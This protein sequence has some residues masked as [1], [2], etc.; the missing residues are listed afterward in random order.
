MKNSYFLYYQLWLMLGLGN[1][2]PAQSLPYTSFNLLRLP[3]SATAIA[4][5]GVQVSSALPEPSMMTQNPALLQPEAARRASLSVQPWYADIL[6]SQVAVALPRGERAALGLWVQYL[7]YG[8]IPDTDPGGQTQGDFQAADWSIGAAYSPRLGVFR[9]GGSVQILGSH[10]AGYGQYALA[11]ILGGVFRHPD[12]DFQLGLT[13]ANI[14]AGLGGDAAIAPLPLELRL[15]ASFKPQHMPLRFHFTLRHLPNAMPPVPTEL[16]GN[17]LSSALRFMVLGAELLPHKNFGLMIGYNPLVR[18]TL[19]PSE[20][21]GSSGVFGGFRL[22]TRKFQ[23]NYA[24]GALH[25]AGGRNTL[26]LTLD[27]EHLL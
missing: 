10:I 4:L 24:R 13:I 23:L 5:G 8:T 27:W 17:A 18:Q 19:R 12:R 25:P 15:G 11:G 1:I 2:L 3:N 16:S 21:A 22:H 20:R 6:H 14:G 9:L 7:H 26:T